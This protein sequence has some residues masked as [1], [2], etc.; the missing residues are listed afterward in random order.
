MCV[1]VQAM[2]QTCRLLHGLLANPT[3]PT[4]WGRLELVFL[5]TDCLSD[6][7]RLSSWIQRRLK[8]DLYMMNG[9]AGPSSLNNTSRTIGS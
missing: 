6:F 7:L 5:R 8:G 4:T 2:Q 3:A 1:Y 9:R